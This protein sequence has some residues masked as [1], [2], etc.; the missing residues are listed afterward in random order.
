M[1]LPGYR[2]TAYSFNRAGSWI[3]VPSEPALNPYNKD[4]LVSAWVNFTAA[5][6]GKQTADIMRKGVSFSVGGVYKLEFIAGGRVKCS[7]KGARS[8]V[9]HRVIGPEIS[10]AEGRWHYIACARTGS[11]WSAIVDDTV[12]SESANLGS[13][14]NTMPLSIGSKYG[15]E[16]LPQGVVDEATLTIDD[17]SSD[18]SRAPE[19]VSAAIAR[20]QDRPP[21]ARWPLDETKASGGPR[22]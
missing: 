16:D 1:G 8:V 11:T 22:L 14:R 12:S 9:G 4:F 18:P 13:I 15:L 6:K 7:A 10:L 5:P 19:D 3:Q 21:T 20:L 17:S 2:G